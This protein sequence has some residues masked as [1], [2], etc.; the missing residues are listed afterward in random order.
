MT[1]RPHETCIE[2]PGKRLA[3]CPNIK[4]TYEGWE[5]STYECQK[6]G[7]ARRYKLYEDEMR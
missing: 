2:Q 6:P 3:D 7:C 1:L 5:D 4:C